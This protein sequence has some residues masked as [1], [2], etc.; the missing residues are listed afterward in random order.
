M[1]G[2]DISG[3]KRD[4]YQ[5]LRGVLSPGVAGAVQA[6][7]Q[8]SLA[9]AF[10]AMAPWDIHADDP[11]NGRKVAAVL[12]DARPGD[13]P[14][15]AQSIMLGHFPLATRLSERLWAIPRDAGLRAVLDAAFGGRPIFMHM[16]PTARFILPNNFG[17]AVPPHQ[18][19]TYTQ[20]LADFYTVWVP[21]VEID[22]VCGGMAV[23]EGSQ[24]EPE[25]LD[26]SKSEQWLAAV[27]TTGFRMRACRP[28]SP[29]DLIIFNKQLI[30]VSQ[31]NVSTRTRLSIDMRF[32]PD[33]VVSRKH[34]LDMQHWRVLAPGE[35]PTLARTRREGAA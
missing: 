2:V 25:L 17:A 10:A 18:D 14:E 5:I 33:T 19:I 26:D 23:F 28:M 35:N 24:D 7:L 9:Q 8:E 15:A 20:H 6:F 1:A 34:A 4:G 31:P 11:D 16:P 3:L 27:S 21:L 12:A 32:F 13:L 22:D 29:G 30:H